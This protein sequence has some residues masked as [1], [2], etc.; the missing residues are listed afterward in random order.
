M[1]ETTLAP[2]AVAL[3][4]E[5][6]SHPLVRAATP[7]VEGWSI[8]K[9]VAGLSMILQQA[10]QDNGGSP[11]VT[12]ELLNALISK[13]DRRLSAQVDEI[14]H[15]PTFQATESAWR[16][17]KLLVDRTKFEGPNR[18]VIMFLDASKQEL[19]SDFKNPRRTDKLYKVVFLEE[20]AQYGGEPF[21]AILGNYSFGP[22]TPD[23]AMLERIAEI[24]EQGHAP[25]I[26]AAG[27]QFWGKESF[28]ALPQLND[29]RV[30]NQPRW[31]QFRESRNSNY[32]GL[33]MPRFLLRHPYHPE[34]NP[35]HSFNY[36]E[37]VED[38]H[39][40]YLWGNTAFA[41][42]TRL[43]ESFSNYGWCPYIVGPLAGGTV[44]SLPIHKYESMG[45]KEVKSPTEILIP[46][47]ML[48]D[49]SN[50]G[51][52][53]LV[54]KKGAASACFFYANST[55]RP[56]EFGN[57]PEGKTAETNFKL[58][59]QLPYMFLVCRL[60]HHIQ[61][62][63]REQLG[64]GMNKEQM[65]LKLQQWVK[66]YIS[67][68]LDPDAR[69]QAERPFRAIKITV[70]D[71]PGDPGW[72]S[73]GMQLQPHIKFCGAFFELSLVGSIEPK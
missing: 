71:V 36:R 63:Q 15:E 58:G 10:M 54:Y 8:E 33:T 5:L 6:E 50:E 19:Q 39:D 70:N 41:F 46:D 51:F 13:I 35:I 55:Q 43:T 23:V 31:Q 40:K 9:T 61:V 49:L 53:P 73:V 30:A 56:K 24:A 26:A 48:I 11:K 60:A 47:P 16:G 42:G 17:L 1:K 32:V 2:P 28:T 65:Q 67:E 12:I 29:F 59:T 52:I 3:D 7:V 22:S 20:Y 64:K 25:F 68:M 72:F 38:N 34:E 21:G 62:F 18:N 27:P 4:V 14:L 66:Q 57:T 45:D 37:R 44:P 69:T